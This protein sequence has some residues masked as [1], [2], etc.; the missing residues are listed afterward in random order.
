M[1]FAVATVRPDHEFKVRDALLADGHKVYCPVIYVQRLN[2]WKGMIRYPI[3]MLPGY[4]FVDD[5]KVRGGSILTKPN[6]PPVRLLLRDKRVVVVPE[7]DIEQVR[8][9]ETELLN[10]KHPDASLKL[11]DLVEVVDGFMKGR[12]GK[13]V[14]FRKRMAVVSF[15][16]KP[17][18]LEVFVK[19][20]DLKRGK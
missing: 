11:K 14:G 18:S 9:V 13:I 19:I 3:P 7:R 8:A 12:L 4:M 20:G 15:T 16:D 10:Q 5:E 6:V 1:P 2:R 17:G